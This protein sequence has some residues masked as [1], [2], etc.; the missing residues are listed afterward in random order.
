MEP[1]AALA[2]AMAEVDILVDVRLIEVDQLVPVMLG[3][4]Q[5]GAELFDEGVPPF[6][7]GAAKQ[8]AR[9]LARGLPGLLPRQAQ[10]VQ[11]RADGFTAAQAAKPRLHEADQPLQRPAGFRVG[12]GDGWAGRVLLG[13][14]DLCAEGG[15]DVRA[16][17][18]RPPVRR[19][20]SAS[21]PCSL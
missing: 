2:P 10:P 7:V 9:K 18:G 14:A 13:C 19:Y 12:A 20:S 17:G 4:V 5:Q 16:K 1:L 11:G 15:C 3:A 8:H 6:G 21:G